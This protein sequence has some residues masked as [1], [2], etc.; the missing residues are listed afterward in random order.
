MRDVDQCRHEKAER[1]WVGG[2]GG[3]GGGVAG[4]CSW[5]LEGWKRLPMRRSLSAPNPHGPSVRRPQQNFQ[6]GPAP[7]ASPSHP[8]LP[9][10]ASTCTDHTLTSQAEGFHNGTGKTAAGAILVVRKLKRKHEF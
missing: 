7:S 6:K 5:Y 9:M 1:G 4:T 8:P 2:G 3:G 10:P